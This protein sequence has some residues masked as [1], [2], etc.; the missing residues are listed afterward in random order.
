MARQVGPQN[1]VG[2]EKLIEPIWKK[3]ESES[4]QF[5]ALWL[6]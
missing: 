6:Q 1:V 3:L 4:V 2:R 5:T